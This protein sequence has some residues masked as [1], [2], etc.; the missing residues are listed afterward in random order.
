M[1]E[2]FCTI[3]DDDETS[4]Q[5]NCEQ[6][7]SG[8]SGGDVQTRIIGYYEAWNHAKRCIGMK[9]QDI[10]IGSLTHIYYSFGYIK[11]ETYE[12]VP[13]D[14]EGELSTD[15]FTEFAGLKRKNPGLKVVIALG[16]WT[17]ND[18]GTIWQPVFSDLA[19]TEEKRGRFIDQ[20][21]TFMNRYGFDG[22]DIDWEYPGAG[23]RGGR[24]GDGENL[25]KLMKQMRATFD[26]SSTKHYE[27]SFTAPTSYWV[28]LSLL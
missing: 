17:F 19:S 6:P 22:V 2:E 21:L 18:N 3:T 27:I 24:D 16:G 20:L 8:S 25:T 23:D 4:C 12:I 7:G 9:I 26:E 14:D 5:S 13:M 1:T 11:P 15:S 28:C 10:P